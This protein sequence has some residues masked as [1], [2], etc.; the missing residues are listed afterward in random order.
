[1]YGTANISPCGRYRYT[2]RRVWDAALP[3]V[4]FIMLNPST[5]D[6]ETDDPTI[7]RVV[8]FARSW[9]FGSVSVFN[10]FALRATDP[11]ELFRTVKAQEE[12]GGPENDRVLASIPADRVV[13]AAWGTWAEEFTAR[14]RYVRDMFKGRLRCLGLTK[15]GH[16]RHPLYVRADTQ[17]QEFPERAS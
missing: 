3:E 12:T 17:H 1:M 9:G 4:S 2:L 16:P 15:D 13:V 7:R 8:G 5:A 11:S 14:E 6:A 10:L